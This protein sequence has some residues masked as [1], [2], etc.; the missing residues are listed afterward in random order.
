MRLKPINT[1]ADVPARYRLAAAAAK[2]LGWSIQL[3]CTAA[4]QRVPGFEEYEL[5]AQPPGESWLHFYPQYSLAHAMK[6]ADAMRARVE[7]DRIQV[8]VWHPYEDP[9]CTD[10]ARTGQPMQDICRAIMFAA[11]MSAPD[12]FVFHEPEVH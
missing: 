7:I 12:E 4:M 1:I 3:R 2:G 8:N 5:W 6:L 11:A 9:V 10:Y